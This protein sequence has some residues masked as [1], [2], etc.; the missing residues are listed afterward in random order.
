MCKLFTLDETRS[1]RVELILLYTMRTQA[2][3]WDISRC[4]PLHSL[5]GH[6]EAVFAVDVDA[7]DS[8]VFT[9]SADKVNQHQLILKL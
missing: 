4:L 8:M 5:E 2:K 1:H 7:K 3:V 9:G 6:K